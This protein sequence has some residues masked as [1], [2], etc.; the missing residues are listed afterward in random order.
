MHEACLLLQAE[1]SQTPEVGTPR[2]RARTRTTGSG[3]A[4]LQIRLL[5]DDDRPRQSV[6]RIWARPSAASLFLPELDS[7]TDRASRESR[8]SGRPT[9]SFLC[10][11]LRRMH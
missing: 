8:Q 2:L 6:T 10:S 9:P 5:D 3:L 1:P 11:F 7:T 4:P